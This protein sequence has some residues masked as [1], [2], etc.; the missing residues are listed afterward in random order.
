M[1][2]DQTKLMNFESVLL[3]PVNV[4]KCLYW[5][6]WLEWVFQTMSFSWIFI[7]AELLCSAIRHGQILL[8]ITL[9]DLRGLEL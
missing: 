2:G 9:F 4:I 8:I 6:V 5:E 1:L 3:N 7:Q